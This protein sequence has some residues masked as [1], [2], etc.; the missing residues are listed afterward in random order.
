MLVVSTFLILERVTVN[1]GNH[2]IGVH[3]I[4]LNLGNGCVHVRGA[5]TNV[6]SGYMGVN[7]ELGLEVNNQR[8][9]SSINPT[10]IESMKGPD[11]V[12]PPGG[13]RSSREK[14]DCVPVM[15]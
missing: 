11:E 7:F 5:S 1:V 8:H 3:S 4:A 2:G 9:P 6:D 12:Q 10:H 13:D 15:C 14:V